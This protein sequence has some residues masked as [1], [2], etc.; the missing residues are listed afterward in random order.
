MRALELLGCAAFGVVLATAVRSATRMSQMWLRTL[1][2]S[3]ETYVSVFGAQPRRNVSMTLK[4]L[5][6]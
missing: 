6:S 5:V 3:S 1:R 4:H 2:P